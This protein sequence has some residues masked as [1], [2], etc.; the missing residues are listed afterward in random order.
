MSLKPFNGADPSSILGAL[1][2]GCFEEQIVSVPFHAE[3]PTAR[4][5]DGDQ[6]QQLRSILAC[7]PVYTALGITCLPVDRP[8]TFRRTVRLETIGTLA[9]LLMLGGVHREFVE[10]YDTALNLSRSFLDSALRHCYDNVEAYSS[11]EAWCEW[12]IGDGILDATVL[13]RDRGDWWLLAVT[14]T[15]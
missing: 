13:L 6:W 5:L 15:D 7:E 8:A 14:G 10:D 1:Q 9:N 4:S 2:R 12:F 11:D 3:L